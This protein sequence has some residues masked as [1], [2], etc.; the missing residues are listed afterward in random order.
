[1]WDR[2]GDNV[3]KGQAQDGKDVI[4]INDNLIYNYL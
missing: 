4:T 1:M 3:D 2:Y